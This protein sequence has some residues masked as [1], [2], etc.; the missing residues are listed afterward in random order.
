MDENHCRVLGDFSRPDLEIVL[1]GCRVTSA[2][3]NALAAILGRNQGPTKLAC[4]KLD[5]SALANGLRGNSRLRNFRQSLRPLNYYNTPEDSER[6]AL[7]IAGNL[8]ENKGLV[9]LGLR[10]GS[11]ENDDTWVAVCD[12]LKTHPTLEIF[13][14]RSLN[15]FE[16]VEPP[17]LPAMINSR[18]QVL[19]DMLKVNTSIRMLELDY[20]YYDNCIFREIIPYV[21]TNRFRLC[22]RAIQKTDPILYRAKVLG[23][24]L[25]SARTDPNRFW[26]LLSG[27]AEVSFP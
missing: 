14:F 7:L 25:L 9:K 1:D 23:R 5:Y 21:E 16:D 4:C 12:S 10:Y 17:V 8:R 24:A 6:E 27:N 26:M 15:P 13:A 3:T 11:D 19:L 22:V 2:G 18:L 20:R